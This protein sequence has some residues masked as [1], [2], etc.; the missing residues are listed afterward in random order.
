[1]TGLV[2]AYCPLTT[3]GAEET[4]LQT[5][6]ETRFV[7]DCKVNPVAL[8]GHLTI[9]LAPERIMVSCGG[10]SGAVPTSATVCPPPAAMAVT[11]FK[12]AGTID[13]PHSGK[14]PVLVF[15]APHATSVALTFKA[16]A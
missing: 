15:P 2:T 8:V 12:P 1:M 5:V 13:W 9:T 10:D 7:V 11:P 3:T 4:A 6:G 16:T 14:T